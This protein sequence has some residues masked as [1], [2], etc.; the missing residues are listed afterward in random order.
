MARRPCSVA[1]RR[2]A[3]PDR[4][5]PRIAASARLLERDRY[6]AG[7]RG[8]LHADARRG[9][10][11]FIGQATCVDCH[12]P[13]LL[14]DLEFHNIGVAQRVEPVRLR[15]AYG[16]LGGVLAAVRKQYE[17]ATRVLWLRPLD[18]ARRRNF[19]KQ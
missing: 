10:A 9:L 8:A 19:A 5:L 12:R 18:F 15:D 1:Q 7:D 14:S 6:V 3:H 13:P 16:E 4:Q 17:L 11:L 2:S